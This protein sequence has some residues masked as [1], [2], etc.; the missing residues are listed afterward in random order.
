MVQ[1]QI[2]SLNSIEDQKKGLHRKM[3]GIVPYIE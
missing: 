2:L 3:K 1:D